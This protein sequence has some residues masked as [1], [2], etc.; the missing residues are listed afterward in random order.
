MGY[1]NKFLG[2][3]GPLAVALSVCLHETSQIYGIVKLEL[4]STEA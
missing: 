4:N 2:P 3:L 1:Y